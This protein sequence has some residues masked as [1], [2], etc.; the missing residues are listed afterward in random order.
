MSEKNIIV[1]IGREFGSGGR[2]IGEK[3]AQKLNINFYDRNLIELAA[4]RSGLDATSVVHSDER[5]PGL[6]VSGYTPTVSDQLFFAQSDLIRSLAD[7]ES[8]VIVGRCANSVLYGYADTLDV[9]V[10]APLN[11][12]IDRIRKRY[13][14]DSAEKAR[15]EIVRVDKIRRTYYQYYSEFRWGSKEGFDLM[16]NS[17]L[18][19]IDGTVDL[20][21]DIVKKDFASK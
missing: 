18:F 1:T 15:K 19:G 17:S 6:F 8:F 9:F 16:L 3:L 5:A 7:N 20:L 21:A 12:R 11:D 10:Y 14:L 4:K 2:E 13:M